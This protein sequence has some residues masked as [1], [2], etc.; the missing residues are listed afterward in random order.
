MSPGAPGGAGKKQG[1]HFYPDAD[2]DVEQT[3]TTGSII[4]NHDE[5]DGVQSKRGGAKNITY[6]FCDT[7]FTGCSQAFAVLGEMRLNVGAFVPIRKGGDYNRF[8]QS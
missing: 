5:I 7:A 8:A 3:Q 4:W 6:T 1:A 2:V